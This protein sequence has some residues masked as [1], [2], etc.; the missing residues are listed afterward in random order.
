MKARAKEQGSGCRL[1]GHVPTIEHRS[2]QRTF[3]RLRR[4]R[5][6]SAGVPEAEPS[7][8]QDH[9]SWPTDS[10]VW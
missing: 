1:S 2:P 8:V 9:R 10:H 6:R 7:E 5:V 4:R 3:H